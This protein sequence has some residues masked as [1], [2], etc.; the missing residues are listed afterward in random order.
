MYHSHI[1]SYNALTLASFLPSIH[2]T[3][4]LDV[5]LFRGEVV[6]HAK[7]LDWLLSI[8]KIYLSQTSQPLPM[9]CLYIALSYLVL[10]LFF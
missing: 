1:P 2:P 4:I 6:C 8:S 9:L 7:H 3:I 10:T 5:V